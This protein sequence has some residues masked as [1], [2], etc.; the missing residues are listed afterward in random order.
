MCLHQPE[1][2]FDRQW[3]KDLCKEGFYFHYKN[4]S[5]SVRSFLLSE[6]PFTEP[7]LSSSLHASFRTS[8]KQYTTQLKGRPEI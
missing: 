7:K 1:T 8:Q 6:I 2:S 3:C 4:R 5:R